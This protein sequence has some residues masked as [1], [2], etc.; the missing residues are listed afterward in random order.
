MK[1][2]SNLR[3]SRERCLRGP[4]ENEPP[5]QVTQGVGQPECRTG[6]PLLADRPHTGEKRGDE[7]PPL[8]RRAQLG[9]HP[10]RPRPFVP[11]Y[12]EPEGACPARQSLARALAHDMVTK[13]NGPPVGPPVRHSAGAKF[14]APDP[15]HRQAPLANFNG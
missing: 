3:R 6:K 13:P 12:P 5:C 7:R 4:A 9:R 14:L 15:E 2:T 1:P 8:I 10:R 11:R